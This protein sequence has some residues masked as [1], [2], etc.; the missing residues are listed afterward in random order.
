LHC[1]GDLQERIAVM[2]RIGT[3]PTASQSR[4]KAAIACRP[5]VE[6]VDIATLRAM[7]AQLEQG[8]GA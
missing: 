5:P 6:E 3:M 1:N 4:A 8:R 7:L 2:D